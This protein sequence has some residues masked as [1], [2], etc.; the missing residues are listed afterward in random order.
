MNASFKQHRR[1]FVVICVFLLS[2]NAQ[3]CCILPRA[4]AYQVQ[5]I[6]KKLRQTPYVIQQL[7]AAKMVQFFYT[8]C[9]HVYL[10]ICIPTCNL[11]RKEYVS[12]VYY[13]LI[14]LWNKLKLK[15]IE[16]NGKSP[17]SLQEMPMPIIRRWNLWCAA[18]NFFFCEQR[19]ATVPRCIA[20]LPRCMEYRRG[21]AMRIL[22]VCLSVRPSVCLS[23]RLLNVWF[24]TKWKKI[25]P[26][27]HITRKII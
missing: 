7:Q 27:S 12:F 8:T 23:V 15:Y 22:S 3:L 6:S 20:F 9:I 19:Q 14:Y 5:A 18:S 10:P 4:V 26:D 13:C 24:V 21:L 25:G 2:F 1:F 11:Y 17:L 16:T